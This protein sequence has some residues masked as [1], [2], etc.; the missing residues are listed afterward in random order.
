MS[1]RCHSFHVEKSKRACFYCLAH[2]CPPLE[3]QPARVFAQ[4]RH[5]VDLGEIE[6]DTAGPAGLFRAWLRAALKL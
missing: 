2:A 3:E 1:D 6:C 5:L 4:R